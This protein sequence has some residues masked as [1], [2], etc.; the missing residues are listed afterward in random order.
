MPIQ[1]TDALARLA[2]ERA[3]IGY[4]FE[5]VRHDTGDR[6]GF[7]TANIAY[8]LQ[9]EDIGPQLKAFLR[10]KADEGMF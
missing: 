7:I 5:G 8:A 1:L 10:Q 6:L 4:E 3:L 9:R 2:H